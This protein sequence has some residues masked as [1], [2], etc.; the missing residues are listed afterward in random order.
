M[1]NRIYIP[2]TLSLNIDGT[3]HFKGDKDLMQSYF[4]ELMKGDSMVNVEVCLTRV[5]SKKTNPQLA[6]FYSTLVP[7][8]RGGFEALTGE[9]YTK[10]EVVTYLKD[11]FFY[12]ET[13]FQG[14]FIK[15]PLSLSKGKKEEVNEF[16]KQVINFA[17]DTLG[18]PVP[19]LN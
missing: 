18:V 17:T 4:R 3:I 11:K 7:I 5:D 12:E 15:T 2:A 14:Q 8:I 10:E 19:E 13:M 16:I 1:I 9:V 6:Y